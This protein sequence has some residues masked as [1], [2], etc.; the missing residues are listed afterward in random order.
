MLRRAA[1]LALALA[2]GG[3]VERVLLHDVWE[4]G[5][6]VDL[7][8]ARD[9]TADWVGLDS[10]SCAMTTLQAKLII[11]PSQLWILLDRSS[12]MQALFD[13]TTRQ[14]AVESALKTTI[15]NY[16]GSVDFGF[17]QFP[18]G[19]TD[20][21]SCAHNK[22]CAGSL[23][24]PTNWPD[25]KPLILCDGW[26]PSCDS[27]SADSPSYA[28]L[29]QMDGYFIQ[30]TNMQ[31]TNMRDSPPAYILLVTS[32][33]PSCAADSS[34][35]LCNQALSATADLANNFAVRTTVL[36]VGS[37]A[38]SFNSCLDKLSRKSSSLAASHSGPTL[39]SLYA[40]S[41][42]PD[43]TSALDGVVSTIAQQACTIALTHVTIPRD[44]SQISVSFDDGTISIPSP[45]P[46]NP[47]AN[48]WT[49]SPDSIRFTGSDCQ[50][51]TT[52]P[53]AFVGITT[54]SH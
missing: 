6:T 32:S 42:I 13:G 26:Q 41:S 2:L 48:G 22:C 43:L 40:V 45:D 37:S 7:G 23:T 11:Q 9:A 33:D 14:A 31:A 38:P 47:N 4:D 17:E 50:K 20:G 3:C 16:Q 46:G 30:A 35:N 21:A 24:P 10:G 52:G 53:V 54:C 27:P 49:I 34:S 12:A 19:P 25:L 1:C 5:G 8:G 39:Q 36:N 15:P 28:A 51:I 29:A 44:H 18:A